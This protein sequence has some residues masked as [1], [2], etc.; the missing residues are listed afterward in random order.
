[1]KIL[2][3][4]SATGRILFI[5]RIASDPRPT[6]L[7]ARI[8]P[9]AQSIVPERYQQWHE[10]VTLW[11][12]FLKPLSLVFDSLRWDKGQ[13]VLAAEEKNAAKEKLFNIILPRYRDML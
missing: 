7:I 6:E 8:A 3:G 1:M 12:F 4:A 10:V 5:A 11:W 2:S 13:H 9:Q